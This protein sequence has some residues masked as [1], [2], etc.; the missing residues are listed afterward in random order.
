VVY[1]LFKLLISN[2]LI[3]FIMALKL[4]GEMGQQLR[5][6]VVLVEDP[7][8]VPASISPIPKDQISLLN[9]QASGIHNFSD[10]VL[11]HIKI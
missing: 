3:F 2:S 1:L 8:L 7:R 5:T 4:S 11:L 6:I 10:K 9:S